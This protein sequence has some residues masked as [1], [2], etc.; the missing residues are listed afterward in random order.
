M[1][2][3]E[4]EIDKEL[5]ALKELDN[6]WN[7]KEFSLLPHQYQTVKRVV[8]EMQGR[9]LLADEVGL[10]K[11]IEAG[12]ILKEYLARGEIETC[13][14]LTPASLGFQWWNELTDKFQIDAFNNRK[15]KGWHYFDVI[16]SS[17]DKAKR[18]PHC[19]HIYER[20]FDM[21]I[22]DEA[23]KLKNSKTMNWNFVNK[24]PKDYLLLLTATPI[25]NDL[26]E[27]YNLVSLVQPKLFGDYKTFKKKYIQGKH[28]VQN[29]DNL[30]DQLSEVMVRNR[31]SKI[32]LEYTD[33]R[34]KL[35]SVNLTPP[36]QELY[37][38]ITDLV[39]TEYKK[40]VNKNKSIFHL[41]TLQREV[42]SSSFAVAKTLEKMYE[43]GYDSIHDQLEELYQLAV[44]IQNNQKMKE[45]E[46][47]LDDNPG[48][49]IIFTEYQGTQ[50]Y[51]GYYL[52]EQ[53]YN[54][55]FFNGRLSDSQK[56]WAKSRFM[57]DG[58]VLISTEAGGQGINLQF[59]NTIINYDLPW[60]PMKIEQRIGRVHRLG[61]D[62]DVLIYNLA[63]KN[64]IEEKI[65]DLL[66]KKI[67]LFESVI[68]GLNNLVVDRT[69]S[70]LE[71]SIL[72]ILAEANDEKE[73][74]NKLD[75][76]GEDLLQEK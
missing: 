62:K 39:T 22:V 10:G 59:C 24:I 45:V 28:E 47:I 33:R 69:N 16:I 48:K 72:E 50:S 27:L 53:G 34:V 1:A 43:D 60:N 20:G 73:I 58:D 75:K 9:A 74:D 12:M 49:A 29:L 15:G 21:V 54:P 61:Q 36:E 11:T 41:L 57:K 26:K 2:I 46:K 56:E 18:S 67:N 42:C 23:H 25:Q 7:E 68:G 64:T 70:N 13:L 6:Y 17:L 71:S 51:I 76:L 32:D 5:V 19:D 31:R 30:Q 52:N 55:V 66:D 3:T 63:T 4:T 65:I 8:D 35:V 37:Q 44:S 38:R 14:V 40:C